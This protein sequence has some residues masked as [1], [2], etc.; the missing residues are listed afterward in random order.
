ML[1]RIQDIQDKL[2]KGELTEAEAEELLKE[3]LPAKELLESGD[4]E[5]LAKDLEA[6]REE[7]AKAEE[8]RNEAEENYAK[9]HEEA[10]KARQE[11]AA[12][13]EELNQLKEKLRKA[14][15]ELKEA[16]AAYEEA[17]KKAEEETATVIAGGNLDIRSNGEVG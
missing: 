12:S 14:E 8:A 11:Y 7:F 10:E 5:K 4:I 17:K 1:N 15:E 6:A 9:A 2:E 16:K 13:E 3:L